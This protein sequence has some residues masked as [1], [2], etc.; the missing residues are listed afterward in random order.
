VRQIGVVLCDK[1]HNNSAVICQ[2]SV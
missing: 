1:E 2:M